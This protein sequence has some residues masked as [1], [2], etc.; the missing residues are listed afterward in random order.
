M[1]SSQNMMSSSVN[2]FGLQLS[3]FAPQQEDNIA[4]L[5]VQGTDG[6]ICELLPSF[7][8]MGVGLVCPHR[9]T[10]IEQQN[11]LLGPLQSTVRNTCPASPFIVVCAMAKTTE[12]VKIKEVIG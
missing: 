11:T 10:Y 1:C 2:S 3:T 4:S 5:V 7:L 6:C 9:E 12:P 8:C